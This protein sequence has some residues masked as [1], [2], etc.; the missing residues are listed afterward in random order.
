MICSNCKKENP[1][2]ELFCKHCG[3]LLRKS[4]NNDIYSHKNTNYNH[5]HDYDDYYDDLEDTSEF[6]YGKDTNYNN[7][8]SNNYKKKRKSNFSSP[9]NKSKKVKYKK[10]KPK[11]QKSPRYYNDSPK[12]VNKTVKRG[13][14]FTAFL[15]FIIMA[16]IA[17]GVLGIVVVKHY[18]LDTILS[19]FGYQLNKIDNNSSVS[20]DITSKDNSNTNN[21]NSDKSDTS[22]SISEEIDKNTSSSDNSENSDTLSDNNMDTSN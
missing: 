6:Y 5:N 19:K 3:Y 11:K 18:G 8:Q 20:D 12:V 4:I 17:S 13:G 9:F 1:D 22:S 14:C 7:N 16:I 21:D 10:A 2:D 15:A